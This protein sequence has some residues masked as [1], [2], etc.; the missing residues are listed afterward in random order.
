MC[1]LIP[2]L[3]D[4]IKQ[5]GRWTLR[6]Y[7]HIV[8]DNIIIYLVTFFSYFVFYILNFYMCKLNVK[9]TFD[10]MVEERISVKAMYI[11]AVPLLNGKKK[12]LTWFL[13]TFY[14]IV[15]NSRFFYVVLLSSTYFFFYPLRF[16][17]IFYIKPHKKW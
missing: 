1:I 6:V 16:W 2:K 3:N 17:S 8:S 5:I 11:D 7:K 14:C 13:P 9:Y 4:H 12:W 10:W 15:G